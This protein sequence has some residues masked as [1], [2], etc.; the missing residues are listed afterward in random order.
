MTP[1]VCAIEQLRENWQHL[2]ELIVAE[3]GT[4]DVETWPP[5]LEAPAMVEELRRGE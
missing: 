2:A 5:W 3:G 1:R 4:V